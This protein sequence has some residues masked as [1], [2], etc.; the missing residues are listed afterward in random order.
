MDTNTQK[1]WESLS[2]RKANSTIAIAADLASDELSSVCR[3]A[4]SWVADGKI[5]GIAYY[6]K[7]RT[8]EVTGRIP[9]ET[10][11]GCKPFDVVWDED[12]SFLVK[13]AIL[14]AY[15]SEQ[16]FLALKA[17]Y[18]ASGRPF[19]LHDTYIRDLRFLA[20]TYLPNLGND[21]L[22]SILHLMKIPVD[23]DDALSRAMA[24]IGAL[25]W[26]EK[27]YPITGYGIPLSAIMAGALR[28]LDQTETPAEKEAREKRQ[29]KYNRL[30]HRAKLGLLPF[31]IL[32][33]FLSLYYVH[34]HQEASQTQVNF[35]QYSA[36]A[37]PQNDSH[38]GKPVIQDENTR[39]LMPRGSFVILQKEALSFFKEASRKNDMNTVRALLKEKKIIVLSDMT[40]IKITGQPDEDHYVPIE[41]VDGD[42]SGYGGFAPANMINK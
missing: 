29:E 10:L 41:I 4:L 37:V 27:R 22:T 35:S 36:T 13:N 12:I 5:H 21:S 2:H 28:P 1:A 33:L 23:L 9:A 17:S 6:I 11:A 3:L 34:R 31:L 20:V 42:Y 16:L 8:G 30:A 39:Y 26:L 40:Q 25:T 24:C 19:P 18:E 15:R 14:S 38:S 7:P 32:C